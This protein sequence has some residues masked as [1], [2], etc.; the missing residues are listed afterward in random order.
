MLSAK[1]VEIIESHQQLLLHDNVVK[2]SLSEDFD[3]FDFY[4]RSTAT[5]KVY[6]KSR[7]GRR[8]YLGLGLLR[9]F[10]SEDVTLEELPIF[11]NKTFDEM[12]MDSQW[13]EIGEGYHFQSNIT[14]VKKCN[15]TDIYLVKGELFLEELKKLTN[16]VEGDFHGHNIPEI[17]AVL[18]TPEIDQWS[19]SVE[20]SVSAMEREE[21]DKVVLARKYTQFYESKLDHSQYITKY[22][23]HKGNNFIYLL[24]F[25]PDKSFISISPESLLKIERDRLNIDVIAGTRSLGDN[26]TE[27]LTLATEL[28]ND[29]KEIHE[30]EIVTNEIEKSMLKHCNQ[31]E[32]VFSKNILKQKHVQHLYSLFEGAL[33][34]DFQ[35][36]NLINDLHPT[37]AVGGTPKQKALEIIRENEPFAR[38]LYAA[39]C[40]V[41]SKDYSELLVAIR[42]VLIEK[43]SVNIFAGAGIVKG[44]RSNYEWK[45]TTRKM[46]N[47]LSPIC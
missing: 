2:I 21:F 9:N 28:Q 27:N 12:K 18:N 29:A 1:L 47:F 20:D 16:I 17:R 30:H 23:A 19:Q 36:E 44:S 8:E 40:G 11:Y 43:D 34:Y 26:E 35:I 6:Y 32:L 39:P 15:K 3:L 33:K 7:E 25:A 37:P 24:N 42:S 4:L 45:E 22:I 10:H 14:F 41:I 5:P 31:Y 46:R 13:Q 38:G